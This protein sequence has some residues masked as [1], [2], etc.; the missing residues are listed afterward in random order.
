MRCQIRLI[1]SEIGSNAAAVS[2]CDYSEY[3]LH[4]ILPTE[5]I[6]SVTEAKRREAEKVEIYINDYLFSLTCLRSESR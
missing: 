4:S 1:F 3:N 6:E 5:C 2:A